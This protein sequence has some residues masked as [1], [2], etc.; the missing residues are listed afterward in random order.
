[1]SKKTRRIL[2]IDIKICASDRKLKLT[3]QIILVFYMIK[4]IYYKCT[5]S[6]MKGAYIHFTPYIHIIHSKTPSI[7]NNSSKAHWVFQHFAPLM[8]TFKKPKKEK[9]IKNC[10]IPR[11]FRGHMHEIGLRR[12]SFGKGGWVPTICSSSMAP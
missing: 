6:S 11:A 12:V 1:M 8:E 4:P 7:T 9:K 5:L 10:V 3:D 2:Q